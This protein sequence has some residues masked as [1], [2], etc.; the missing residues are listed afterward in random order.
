M[1]TRKI[2]VLFVL[3]ILGQD[4]DLLIWSNVVAYEACESSQC[5]KLL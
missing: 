5:Y 1:R 2:S 4:L 3:N